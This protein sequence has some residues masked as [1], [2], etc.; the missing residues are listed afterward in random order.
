MLGA[1]S[2]ALEDLFNGGLTDIPSI[3]VVH[4]ALSLE[5]GTSPPSR[6]RVSCSS[7]R[8]RATDSVIS[9]KRSGALRSRGPG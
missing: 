5:P 6:R 7:S 8:A 9:S 3:E 1:V 2:P 4:P